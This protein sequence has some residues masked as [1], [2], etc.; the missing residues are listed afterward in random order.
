MFFP[1]FLELLFAIMWEQKAMSDAMLEDGQASPVSWCT[2]YNHLLMNSHIMISAL[3]RK[4]Y[5]NF[6]GFRDC[7]DFF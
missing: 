4:E 2:A 7:C 1:S 6:Q 5:L 3:E